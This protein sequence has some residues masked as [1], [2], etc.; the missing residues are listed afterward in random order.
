M[1]SLSCSVVTAPAVNAGVA[2]CSSEMVVQLMKERMERILRVMQLHKIKCVVLG[3]FGCGVFKNDPVVV[4]KIW[5]ELLAGEFKGN[6]V[7]KAFFAFQMN[8]TKQK[9][10][11]RG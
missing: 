11:L 1:E 6:D 10:S 2:K 5:Q 9:V 3:A 4:A 8:Q 7:Q